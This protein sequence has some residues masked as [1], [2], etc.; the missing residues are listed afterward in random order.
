MAAVLMRRILGEYLPCMHSSERDLKAHSNQNP[1]ASSKEEKQMSRNAML[2][3]RV[4]EGMRMDTAVSN[5]WLHSWR[6]MDYLQWH[7]KPK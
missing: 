6:M 5:G 3:D 7:L 2:R 1:Y 4:T